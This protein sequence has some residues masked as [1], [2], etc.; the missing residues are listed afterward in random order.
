MWNT[1]KD[2]V[3]YVERGLSRFGVT[4]Y[5]LESRATAN[6]I[7]DMWCTGAGDD[8]FIE[9]KNCKKNIPAKTIHVDWRPG[10]VAFAYNYWHGHMRAVNGFVYNKCSWTIIGYNDGIVMVPMRQIYAENKVPVKDCYIIYKM[11]EKPV[12]EIITTLRFCSWLPSLFILESMAQEQ[13]IDGLKYLYN[14]HG[15]IDTGD[16]KV[17]PKYLGRFIYDCARNQ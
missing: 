17:E 5:R 14:L 12:K 1:E 8:W 10:Q 7:P 9:F 13:L 2:F 16:I 11:H 4:C 6:G 3:E 15:D